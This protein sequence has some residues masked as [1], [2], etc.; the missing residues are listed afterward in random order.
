MS[1]ARFQDSRGDPRFDVGDA[2]RSMYERSAVLIEILCKRCNR[3]LFE[4]RSLPHPT[5]S[6]WAPPEPLFGVVRPAE[7]ALVL[8]KQREYMSWRPEADMQRL[9]VLVD[10]TCPKCG[11]LRIDPPLN[12]DAAVSSAKRAGTKTRVRATRAD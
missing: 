1:R 9:G 10:V 5:P 12:L 8:K 6:E 4:F 2:R 7:N 11:R 3:I